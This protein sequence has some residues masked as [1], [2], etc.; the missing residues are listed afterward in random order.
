MAGGA[1]A[2]GL[3]HLEWEGDEG[4]KNKRKRLKW[5]YELSPSQTTG[6]KPQQ[7]LDSASPHCLIA[8][9]TFHLMLQYTTAHCGCTTVLKT[10]WILTVH[11]EKV[12]NLLRSLNRWDNDTKYNLGEHTEPDDGV[13]EEDDDQD[14][15]SVTRLCRCSNTRC[16]SHSGGL[17]GCFKNKRCRLLLVGLSIVGFFKYT[18][19]VGLL[20]VSIFILRFIPVSH[21]T[22]IHSELNKIILIIATC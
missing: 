5:R 14:L 7:L 2:R 10:T 9:A 16:W 1:G 19:E 22:A 17:G 12:L 15:R 13:F 3:C 18:S 8:H 20:Y 4:A 11:L 21:F 6:L